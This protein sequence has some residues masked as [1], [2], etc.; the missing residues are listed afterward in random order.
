[1]F[2]LGVFIA[3]RAAKRQHITNK[4][5]GYLS[6]IGEAAILKALQVIFLSGSLLL[7]QGFSLQDH[8]LVTIRRA[9]ERFKKV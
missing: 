3:G 2:G 1:V 5:N 9:S 6:A 8:D 4:A 7:E